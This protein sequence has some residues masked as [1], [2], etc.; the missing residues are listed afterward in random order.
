[1]DTLTTWL[2][3]GSFLVSV[4]ALWKSYRT[5]QRQLELEQRA[6]VLQEIQS[7]YQVSQA[8]R[9]RVEQ[10]KADVRAAFDHADVKRCAVVLSNR[11]RGTA[12][13][14]NVE[15]QGPNTPFA[16]YPKPVLPVKRIDPGDTHRLSGSIS[17]ERKPPWDAR[18]TWTDD[19]GESRTKEIAITW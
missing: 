16:L 9:E 1:M 17:Q 11:G 6:T 5:D 18:L 19:D 4:L 2:A 3:V 14:V 10:S 7:K 13:N 12:H 15:I 8:S